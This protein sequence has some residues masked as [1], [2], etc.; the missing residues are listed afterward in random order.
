MKLIA[1]LFG[2]IFLL[3]STLVCGQD[4]DSLESLPEMGSSLPEIE[5]SL[6]ELGSSLPQPDGLVSYED[7]Y[8]TQF[9]FVGVDSNKQA[10]NN[11]Q[12][13]NN[14]QKVYRVANN[15]EGFYFRRL[16]KSVSRAKDA[17]SKMA[18]VD[19]A[20][21]QCSSNGYSNVLEFMLK[22]GTKLTMEEISDMYL[23]AASKSQIDFLFFMV[24]N[25]LKPDQETINLLFL[26]GIHDDG[27]NVISA[28]FYGGLMPDC[29]TFIEAYKKMYLKGNEDGKAFLRQ[30]VPKQLGEGNITFNAACRPKPSHTTVTPIIKFKKSKNKYYPRRKSI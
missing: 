13:D 17:A 21:F 16:V 14:K 9:V 24:N 25:N 5:S 6:P 15:K 7:Q 20:I 2:P 30:Y 8:N 10:D 23:I 18:I 26:R 19:E 28:L 27:M 12:S 4:K 22:N 29:I 1:F 11:K 3:F